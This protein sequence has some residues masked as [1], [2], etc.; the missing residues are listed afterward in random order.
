MD[1]GREGVQAR[2]A[3]AMSDHT[4]STS[5]NDGLLMVMMDWGSL[6]LPRHLLAEFCRQMCEIVRRRFGDA[7]RNSPIRRAYYGLGDAD[8]RRWHERY[9]SERRNGRRN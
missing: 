5:A 9:R 6:D 8:A 7:C 4:M 2:S 3:S 1:T